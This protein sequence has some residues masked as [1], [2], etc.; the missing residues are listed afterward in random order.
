MA[1]MVGMNLCNY[2]NTIYCRMLYT[3]TIILRLKGYLRIEANSPVSPQTLL[4][5][6]TGYPVRAKFRFCLCIWFWHKPCNRSAKS[7]NGDHN[8]KSATKNF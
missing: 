3:N 2:L 8:G 4:D 1:T 6:E 7:N 5:T